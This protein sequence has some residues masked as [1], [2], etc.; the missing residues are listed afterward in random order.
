MCLLGGLDLVRR[1]VEVKELTRTRDRSF[2]I[3]GGNR[4]AN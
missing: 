4:L 1:L 2:V 3:H